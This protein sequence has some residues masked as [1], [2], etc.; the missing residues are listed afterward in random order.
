MVKD[1]LEKVYS[2]FLGMNI[3][4]RLGAPVEPTI[5][6]YD[7]IR[8]TYGEITD[9]VKE[10]KNFAADDDANG[11]VFF[12]RALYD[13]AKDRELVP[14]DVARAWLNYAREGVGHVLVGR[15]WN[16]HGAYGLPEPEERHRSAPVR[17]CG[18][19]RPISGRADWR[20]DLYRYLGTGKPLPIRKKRLI[21]AKQRPVYPTAERA[22]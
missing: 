10:F 11:P 9:Y 8:N 17:L 22:F 7:R 6:T 21:T 13:D 20:P 15:L 4:I 18:A 16:Q 3:G 1:Y 2:G 19:E 12:I 5:W 14:Q